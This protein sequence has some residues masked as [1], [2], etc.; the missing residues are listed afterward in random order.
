MAY[1]GEF[2]INANT[3]GYYKFDNDLTDSSGNS[4]TWSCS[5]TAT[6][7]GDGVIGSKCLQLS[8]K[9]IYMNENFDFNAEKEYHVQM[10]AKITDAPNNEG[11]MFHIRDSD[12]NMAWAW[13]IQDYLGTGFSFISRIYRY[14]SG[15]TTWTD[16]DTMYFLYN[17]WYLFLGEYTSTT[18]YMGRVYVYYPRDSVGNEDRWNMLL[19]DESYPNPSKF[20]GSSSSIS[21]YTQI[22]FAGSGPEIFIDELV[23]DNNNWFNRVKY[24][25]QF[26]AT[27]APRCS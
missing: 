26:C 20:T 3:K 17:K 12:Y 6:Y 27:N 5:G 13:V 4:R 15:S 14:D 16:S 9:Y 1:L 11:E 10:W 7:S 22:W 25:Q 8:D 18:S 24:W 2:H 23:I 19:A 21:D